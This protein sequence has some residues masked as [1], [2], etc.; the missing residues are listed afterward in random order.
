MSGHSHYATIKR[1]KG[2]KDAQKGLM[3]SKL[4]RA[5]S[6]SVKSGGGPD[7]DSNY[8]LRM[9]VEA[10]RTANMPKEN[11]E[12]A[13]SKGAGSGEALEEVVYEGFAPEGVSVMVEAATDNRNRTAQEL[14]NIFER[15]GGNMGGPGSVAFNFEQKGLIVVEK[16]GDTEEQLLKL[17]DAEVDDVEVTDNG[18]EVYVPTG[19]LSEKGKVL[20]EMD[21][22]VVSAELMQKPKITVTVSDLVKAQKVIAFLD[23]LE[24][25][26]DVQKVFANLNIPDDVL[27][28]I[29]SV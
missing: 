12:R 1:Q 20:Q 22:K 4:A 16:E 23:K 17:I 13:I 19:K 25:Y 9:A 24:E 11:I 2:A 28:Q 8:K 3:F 21:F 14:K 10:A 26:E 27:S 15:G 7:P 6:I 5:I 18:I 29:S